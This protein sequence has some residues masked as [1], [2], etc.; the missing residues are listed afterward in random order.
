MVHKRRQGLTVLE[1]VVGIFIVCALFLPLSHLLVTG[2][3]TTQYSEDYLQALT[4]GRSQIE[5]IRNAAKVDKYAVEKLITKFCV[6]PGFSDFTVHDKFRVHTE[7]DP[8]AYFADIPGV[9]L[10]SG[11]PS[12]LDASLVRVAVRVEWEI[13]GEPRH[14]DLEA[15]VDRAYY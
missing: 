1:V 11:A 8:Q 3:K 14:L 7:V 13:S 12:G 5:M 4:I 9:S 6:S 2:A 15:Y 10:G